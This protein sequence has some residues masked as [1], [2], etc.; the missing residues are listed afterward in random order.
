MKDKKEKREFPVVQAGT[1]I[2]MANRPGGQRGQNWNELKQGNLEPAAVFFWQ[3]RGKSVA[4]ISLSLKTCRPDTVS[5]ITEEERRLVVEIKYRL[6]TIESNPGP[7]DK[8]EEGRE[9]RRNRR[10]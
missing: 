9:A 8:T 4:E 10:K 5:A 3:R 2:R 6:Q 7:R 1:S